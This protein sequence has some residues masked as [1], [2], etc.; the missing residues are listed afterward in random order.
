MG[1]KQSN[2]VDY[3]PCYCKDGKTLFVLE[4]YWGNDGFAFFYRLWKRLGDSNFHYIDLREENNWEYFKAQMKISEAETEKILQKLADMGVIDA[5]LW[6][7]KIV[8]SDSFVES[9]ADV[10]IKRKRKVPQKPLF[11]IQKP[12]FL[13]QKKPETPISDTEG[14]QSRVEY[15]RVEYS[16]V[17]ENKED[18]P[19]CPHQEIVNLWNEKMTPLGLAKVKA[20]GNERKKHLRVRWRENEKHQSLEWWGKFFDYIQ[21][22]DFLMGKK[23]PNDGHKRFFA[24]L[25]WLVSSEERMTKILEGFY[26]RG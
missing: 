26:H 10:W 5:E 3:F 18:A 19:P 1:R 22:S 12:A 7:E 14:T 6:A 16:R 4:S 2:K 8:W 24:T 20:W 21:Q 9:V 15:S 11:L 17:E 13:P 25:P 23:E